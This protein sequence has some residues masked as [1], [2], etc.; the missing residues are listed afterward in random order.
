MGKYAE[1]LHRMPDNA[2][3][4]PTVTIVMPVYNGE[5]CLNDSIG[6][7]FAQS[8]RNIE[9][10]AVNDGSSDDSGEILA[11]LCEKQ[12]EGIEIKAVTQ[13]NSGICSARNRG[14]DLARGRYIA[15]MD[16]DDRMP[17]DYVMHLVKEMEGTEDGSAK[18]DAVIG[19]NVEMRKGL[20]TNRD[21][22]P[23]MPWSLYRN[24][25]PWGRMFRRT[26]IE[27]NHIR[28]YDTRIS[29]DFYFNF[30]YLSFCRKVKVVAQT[31]YVWRIDERSES[32]SGMRRY[33]PERDVTEMLGRLL[34]DMRTID[35]SSVLDKELFEYLI[36]KHI[37]WYLLFISEGSSSRDV[38][39]AYDRAFGWLKSNF[40]D[41]RHNS[42]VRWGKPEGESA[43][44]RHIVTIAVMMQKM[45]LFKP[46]LALRSIRGSKEG[47]C[48]DRQS[49]K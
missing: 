6:D 2:D 7:I 24:N 9:L 48:Y 33:S 11:K 1:D 19:G 17:E 5:C 8:Y 10:I 36:I 29:E 27:E 49:D 41:Y 12:P 21:L 42:Q 35:D 13:I 31:G 18:P 16:Q 34:A 45:N 38:R 15:F 20:R 47:Q 25:A 30:V 22:E 40:P 37:V 23:D 28:F 26:V 46:F 3:S 32:H 43:G 14:L 44:V 39:E 4:L